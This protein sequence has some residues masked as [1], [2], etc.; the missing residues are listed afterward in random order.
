MVRKR[1]SFAE[2][3]MILK[4]YNYFKNES[5]RGKLRIRV[6]NYAKRTEDI[7]KLSRSALNRIV[8]KDKTTKDNDSH[9]ETEYIEKRGRK[10]KLDSFQKDLIKRSVYKFYERNEMMTLK[11]LK[12]YL[13]E[14]ENLNVSK[15]L[16]LRHLHKMGFKY[17][18]DST[19]SRDVICERADLVRLRSSF[20]RT[21]KKKREEGYTVVY[22][23]ETWV[24]ASHTAPYQWHPPNPKDDRRLPTN[25]GERLIV[26]HAGCAEKGFLDGCD[27]VFKAKAKDNRDYHTEMNGK[28]CLEWVENQLIPALPTKSLLVLDNAPYHNIRTE[29]SIAPTSASRKLEMQTW[30]NS[31]G[32]EFEPQ[33]LKPRLYELIKENKPPPVYKADDMIR[34]AGHDT[35][36]LPPYHCN[37]NPIELV[38]GDLKGGI[39]LENSSFKLHD[40]RKLVHEGFQRITQERWQNCVSHVV[41]TVEKTYWKQDGIV[42]DVPPLIISLDSDDESESDE[43]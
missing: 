30:L 31:R 37:L 7:F 42:D 43:D 11:K 6:S 23:D 16:L 28:V 26:L 22:T 29:E 2:K 21:I 27:L 33:A 3:Q 5:D 19:N 36:R 10:D 12:A 34:N 13:S 40:V 9:E 32:I 41:N 18:K 14:H 1:F 20:L 15:Y 8:N 35:L 17:N 39:G 4:V 24:N 38:W 25:R